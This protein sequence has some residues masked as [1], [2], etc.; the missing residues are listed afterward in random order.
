MPVGVYRRSTWRP[1]TS[2]ATRRVRPLPSFPILIPTVTHPPHNFIDPFTVTICHASNSS[3]NRI[4]KFL[5]LPSYLRG[6]PKILPKANQEGP[7]HPSS[8]PPVAGLRLYCRYNRNPPRSSSRIRQ[9][10]QWRREVDQV[11]GPNR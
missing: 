6:C 9:I 5:T 1:P 3:Y 7:S 4:F 8:C 11:V 2:L 10:S